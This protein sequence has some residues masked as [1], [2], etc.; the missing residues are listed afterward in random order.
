MI[1]RF[2]STAKTIQ[3]L[4]TL[5]CICLSHIL[6]TAQNKPL[7]YEAQWQQ[8]DSLI[9]KKGLFKSALTEVNKIYQSAKQ[10]K[11]DPQRIKALIYRLNLQQ[12]DRENATQQNIKDLEQEISADRQPARSILQNMLAG[13]YWSYFQQNR[14]KFYN[15][16]P[17]SGYVKDDIA[18]W[19]PADFHQKV[20]ARYLQSLQ[21]ESLLRQTRLDAYDP[22][23]IRGNVRYLRPTLFELL[24]HMALDY[25][26]NDERDAGKPAYAFEL[27]DPAVFADARTFIAHTF[28]TRDSLS[29]HYKALQ[30]FQELIRFH[31]ADPRPDA[32]LDVDIERL[33]FAH[34]YAVMDDKDNLQLNAL[35]HITSQ[36][37]NEPIAT[38]AWYLQAQ[39]YANLAGRYD[40][41]KDTANRYAY[42]QAKAICERVAN[43]ARDS[44]EGKTQCIALLKHI[45]NKDL[46]LQM[47]K[48]NLPG[49]P[50]RCLVS[51]RNFTQLY[52]RVIRMDRTLKES[53]G[54]NPYQ[55]AYWSALLKLPA[56]K[57]TA[58]S[59]PETDDYQTH[60]TEIRIDA[61]PVGSYALIASVDN[62][63]GLKQA[64]MVVQYFEVSGIAC[65]NFDRNYFIV[66]RESG[67]PLLQ[68]TIQVWNRTYDSRAGKFV[69]V[70]G[71]SYQSDEH[72]YFLLKDKMIDNYNGQLLEITTAKDHFFP[73]DGPMS[74]QYR[75]PTDDDNERIADKIKY[76]K[77]NRQ[78]FFFTDRSIYRP[79][80]TVYFKGILVTRDA[81]T[82]QSKILSSYK[83]KII[84]YNAN[85]GKVDSLELT[86]N[87][88]G[89]CHGT[90]R[91]PD[92][93]LN[94]RFRIE[95]DSTGSSEPFSVEEY[96]RPTFYV[97]YDKMKGSYRLNDTIRV[98][99]S[100]KA[101]AG[102]PI[103]GATIR[104]RVIRHARFPHP[105]LLWRW[106]MPSF[107]EREIAHGEIRTDAEG[108]FT[109]PFSALPDRSINKD[110]DP[111]FEYKVSADITDVGGETR[112]GMTTV[113]TGYKSMLLVV[114]L[115][116]GNYLPADSL[117]QLKISATNLSGEQVPATVNTSIYPLQAPDRLIR[118]R[119]WQEPDQF[120]INEKDYL[121]AFPH[122]EYRSESRKESWARSAKVFDRTDSAGTIIISNR[123][124]P[125]WYVIEVNA[126][127]KYGAD[128]KELQYIELYDSKTG[129]PASP[130][131]QWSFNDG[132][133]VEPGDKATVASG[134]SATDVFLVRKTDGRPGDRTAFDFLT[135][136]KDSRSTAF[137]VTEADRGG[138][139]IADAFIRD[140]RIYTHT[141]KVNVP[142]SNKDLRI[143][144][145]T[146]RDKTLPGSAE[147]WK[148]NISGYKGD[149][150]AAELV[151]A[152]YD[153]SLDQFKPQKWAI[154]DLNRTYTP[155]HS[156]QSL[157][158]FT[159]ERSVTHYLA[160]VNTGN[161]YMKIYDQLE[162][163][164]RPFFLGG[165]RVMY[166]NAQPGVARRANAL[167]GE[168]YAKAEEAPG[169]A[170]APAAPRAAM[171]ADNALADSTIVI[172][173]SNAKGVVTPGNEGAA[174]EPQQVQIRKDMKETAFF[175]P[176]LRTDTAGN[177]SFSFV[178]PE[179]LTQWK[180][181]TLAHTKDLS[182][183]YGEK[184]IVTQKQLMV[185][186]NTPRFLREGDRME[187][188]T[189][190]V[191]LTDM[192]LT[193]QV[194]LQL[195]D[196]A[197]G[198]TADGLFS[199]RQPNQY[200]T[201]GPRQST[202]VG[203][204]IEVPYQYNRP[205]SYRMVASAKIPAAAPQSS[206]TQPGQEVSDGE[207]AVLPVVSNRMLVMETLPLNMPGD[208]ARNFKWERL[209]QSGNSETLN[210]HA[211][212]VEFSSNPAWYAVQALPYLMEYPYECAEQIFNRFYANALAAKIV[213]SSPRIRA[214]FDK[215]KTMDTAAL[216]SN[217][218][219][220]QEL[221][222]VLLEETPWVLQ[223]KSES[224]QKRNIA[225]LFD[226]AR[227]RRELQSA[228]QKLKDMQS[229]GGGFVWF[230]GGIDDRY[231][232]QYILTGIGR[233]QKLDAIPMS[234]Q[235]TIKGIIAAALPYL[236]KKIKEDYEDQMRRDKSG[237]P[238]RPIPLAG[239]AGVARAAN[240]P[241][242][243]KTGSVWIGQLPVQY[244]YAR[245][246]FSDYGIPGD[247]LPAIT[248]FRKQAQQNWLQQRKY[249]QGMIALALNR[250]G[251]VQTAKDIIA[252]LRQSAVR[253][254]ELGMY[255]KDIENGFYWYQ[256]PIETQSLLIEAFRE[257][258]KDATVDRELKTWLLRQKQTR[259]WATTRATADA[260]YAL[261]L[262]GADW[263]S[264]ER[265][266]QIRLGD[267]TISST[268]TDEQSDTR[269][270]MQPP[271][272]PQSQ[273]QSQGQPRT[274][275][276]PQPRPEAG[277]GYFKQVIDGPFVKPSM[278]DITVTLSTTPSAGENPGKQ[279][280]SAGT[281]P[282]W[283]AVYWQYFDNLDRIT[284]PGSSKAPL[285]LVKKLFVEKNTDRGPVLEPVAPNGVLHVGDK[286]K[287]R[288]ELRVDRDME[289][290]HMKDMRASCM[291]PVNVL[292]TYKWQ[293]GLGYYE[294][295]RDASTNFFFGWLPKGTYVFEYPLFVSQN[296]NFSNGVTSI[297]CMYAPEFA[298]HSEGIR[299]N[300]EAATP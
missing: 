58:Q 75:N 184:T 132:A 33:Q 146:Y 209:L 53:L 101:Y 248:Y 87:E 215:W 23:I 66:D 287:V 230:K 74:Y 29:L 229:P 117:R 54:N 79:G 243:G 267:R 214:I 31:I 140:N 172:S 97:E 271:I 257:I 119:Y 80:Q 197:N 200:F 88:F 235:A 188:S 285:Q 294:S 61:L 59:L 128:V 178:T 126:K 78:T 39:H 137:A 6:A 164:I 135:L 272:Q 24:A 41:A 13:L 127:D 237:N 99:G 242:V 282:A 83:T 221:K 155:Q 46:N 289:Y 95:D 14:W 177:V 169:V 279:D 220:N 22:I 245:S 236:D 142:W 38:E 206:A 149:R 199:N 163:G 85:D 273:G 134:S 208:G 5:G 173:R 129:R 174:N 223:A 244:L 141:F 190:I 288:I 175:F 246:L 222:S 12:I 35:A 224:Q 269:P 167:D 70:R 102:N 259:N 205:L 241:N 37:G 210:N 3:T 201:V 123:L 277:T 47:E 226:D 107:R 48:V 286:V 207:E 71:E 147:N 32:L 233:L 15:R 67:H 261:L 225:L 193:G 219:K 44:S 170:M 2:P 156:W 136:N 154:P 240:K 28:T 292:S 91:L 116:G 1:A 27:D 296:G 268:Q 275:T 8:I 103:D 148:V 94:G 161:A 198:K 283:G 17:T 189:R 130:Q 239:K 30:L 86:S 213:S 16:T 232:T 278:G 260:C 280:K 110:L 162:F 118:A 254:E 264:Q 138:F 171:A 180:W 176:D 121:D 104:Y 194:S 82:R 122:D 144:Y 51:W 42:L 89:S 258:G 145:V 92:N 202:A 212:T 284:T 234:T 290:V 43:T 77:D 185:Q 143:S 293:G 105:W 9:N 11:N 183:A 133:T 131:Y 256:A 291:E 295:T 203:F 255:W 106:S 249:M 157:G 108:K 187:L 113:S 274:K 195:T 168:V 179:A 182:F 216:L 56:L 62:G 252:S 76:E 265:S 64:P 112:S 40:P 238:P 247:I 160:P 19:S 281:S 298:Y 196:P 297:E 50:M 69:L 204:S 21:D 211:L 266:V 299:V 263:L 120:V 34:T 60:S 26:K 63:F 124:T 18:T 109:I 84:L 72:G 262:G 7:G 68:A 49:Q 73:D 65:M 276:P 111:V 52:L 150:V 250:T 270:G 159:L 100:A 228:L 218:Q 45:L 139:G 115:P 114:D 98:S 152:M 192:E 4:L 251:D 125:G 153:A 93:L 181:M 300:V 96:K 36:Y 253:S 186:P 20:S 158:N 25:F 81:D 57:A 227:M 166:K 55:D 231:I 165:G 10:D 191:N 90:F 151:A 217:L